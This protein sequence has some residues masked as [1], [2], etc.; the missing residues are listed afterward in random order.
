VFKY[1]PVANVVTSN[2][3]GA[4]NFNN[5]YWGGSLAYNGKIY[6]QPDQGTNPNNMLVLSTNGTGNAQTNFA[7]T[8]QSPYNNH[9][10]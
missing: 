4:T 5:G 8:V 2:S 3:Y 9:T 7:S 6:F 1:D 10:Q